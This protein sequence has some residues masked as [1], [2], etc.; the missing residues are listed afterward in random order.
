MEAATA[1]NGDV[2]ATGARKKIIARS[3]RRFLMLPFFEEHDIKLLRVLTD[4][5]SEF[6]RQPR[7]ARVRAISHG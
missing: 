7:M 2:F 5:G 6:L 3:A 1:L 4:R